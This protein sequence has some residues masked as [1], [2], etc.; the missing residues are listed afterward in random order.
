MRVLGDMIRWNDATYYTR[1]IRKCWVYVILKQ[2]ATPMAD[3]IAYLEAFRDE[4]DK[5]KAVVMSVRNKPAIQAENNRRVEKLLQA[6]V[7]RTK[8]LQSVS[9]ITKKHELELASLRNERRQ[10]QK[11]V[12]GKPALT[13]EEEE[14]VKVETAKWQEGYDAFYKLKWIIDMGLYH[15]VFHLV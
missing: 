12:A 7:A 4:A 8:Q 9:P 10:L 2:L 11:E 5:Q 14:F 13:V 15:V 3:P 1:D 6:N